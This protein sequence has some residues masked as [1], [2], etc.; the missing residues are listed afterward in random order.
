MFSSYIIGQKSVFKHK[1]RSVA[2]D[3]SYHTLYN[4]RL[5]P[6]EENNLYFVETDV[7]T[8][9]LGRLKHHCYLRS[10][11]V[12]LVEREQSD[13]KLYNDIYTPWLEDWEEIEW[14]PSLLDLE[15][16]EKFYFKI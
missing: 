10:A 5:D 16:F 7:R 1:E 3:S 15:R 9:L 6:Y 2:L 13:P 4:I 12:P 14:Q 11:Y 8:K